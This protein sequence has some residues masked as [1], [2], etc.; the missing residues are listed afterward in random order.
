MSNVDRYN[1]GCILSGEI[2]IE[3]VVVVV[4]DVLVVLVLYLVEKKTE[5]ST[6][7][8]VPRFDEAE[9]QLDGQSRI[10]L[11]FSTKYFVSKPKDT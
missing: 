2:L 8:C 9:K 7:D 3:V 5:K 6:I 10:D 11:L 1:V 4:V